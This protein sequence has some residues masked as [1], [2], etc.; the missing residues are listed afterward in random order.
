MSDDFVNRVKRSTSSGTP[1]VVSAD[2]KSGLRILA[3]IIARHLLAGTP[4]P[5]NAS[6]EDIFR[7]WTQ[8][9]N[10]SNQEGGN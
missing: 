7:I 5:G 1:K 3:R 8:G 4:K 9:D 2:Y 6:K 10:W